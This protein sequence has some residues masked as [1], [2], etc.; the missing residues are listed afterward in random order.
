M[1]RS[2]ADLSAP[3]SVR[4]P[5]KIGLVQSLDEIRREK[6]VPFTHGPLYVHGPVPFDIVERF[7][8]DTSIEAFMT[9]YDFTDD[10]IINLPP[11]YAFRLFVMD[12]VAYPHFCKW[13]ETVE[14]TNSPKKQLIVPRRV[15]APILDPFMKL[16]NVTV[17]TPEVIDVW[18]VSRSDCQVMPDTHVE[19]LPYPVFKEGEAEELTR[20]EFLQR[21][22]KPATAPNAVKLR[23]LPPDPRV[24]VRGNA[25]FKEMGVK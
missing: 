21:L 3:P 16:L 2:N 10:P 12:D 24:V 1:K 9:Y 19:T 18:T 5:R 15:A 11:P 8:A 17:P 25:R 13:L 7:V 20:E 22:P 14:I 4:R 23:K 6:F